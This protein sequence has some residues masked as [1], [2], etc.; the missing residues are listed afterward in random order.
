M[1]SDVMSL[2]YILAGIL[3]FLL[4]I[5]I[6]VYYIVNRKEKKKEEQ[7]KKEIENGIDLKTT[8]KNS[9]KTFSVSSV[10]DFME[11]D[12]IVDNM[13]SQ[14]KGKK[15]S[16]VIECQGINYDL[17]S[18]AEQVA[19]EEGFIQFLNTLQNKVQLYIQTRTIN[20]EESIR[21][22]KERLE[23]IEKNYNR[24][25][26]KYQQ[27]VLNSA[28]DSEIKREY[29]ELIK[30]QN[31]YEY[32]LDIIRN[33]EKM[34]L[35]SHML[36]KKYYVIMSYYTAEAEEQNLDK[37]E[38]KERAFSELY[39]RCQSAIRTLAISGVLG[40][41][42]S[43]AELVDLLYVAYNRDDSEIYG[44]DK[45]IKARYDEMYSTAPD[46]M[47]KK[48]RILDEEIER[49]ANAMVNEKIMQAR[50]ELQ[51]EYDERQRNINEI[52]AGMAQSIITQNQDTI[53]IDIADLAK[54]SIEEEKRKKGEEQDVQKKAKARKNASRA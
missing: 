39:T 44:I 37:E 52:I 48:I 45:A 2:L 7:K 16:M 46:Y 27:L 4:V 25:K 9:V 30:K 29:Y 18:E 26:M 15:Y 19:V 12:K 33:T 40:K 11:F 43:S 38:L 22:Y 51:R 24:Q 17:M 28:P 50:S 31:L 6:Y 5:L 23:D 35:N 14:K 41:I 53:G 1:N 42:L 49:Q 36:T 34:S 8:T 54:Q 13:I 47:E 3:G 20:L 21:N 10:F 32:T